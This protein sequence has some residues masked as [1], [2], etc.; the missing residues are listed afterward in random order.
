MR[1]LPGDLANGRC[2]LPAVDLELAGL[3]PE[4]LRNPD[5]WEQLQPVFRPW[6]AKAHEHLAAAWQYTLMI[7]HSHYRLRLACAWP[8]LMG[9]RTL[10]LVE[11]QNPLDPASNLKIDRSQ[12]RGILWSSLWRV[13]FRGP[14]QRLF[15]NK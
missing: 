3:K 7:T 14:W 2:Y 9:R 6:L 13:P 11:H 10:A 1:D 12:V 4:D 8:I 15:G 5:S